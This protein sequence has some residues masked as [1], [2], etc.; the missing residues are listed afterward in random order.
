M[1]GFTNKT[2]NIFG[3]PFTLQETSHPEISQPIYI[4]F[5]NVHSLTQTFGSTAARV[6]VKLLNDR[7]APNVVTSVAPLTIMVLL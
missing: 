3:P 6:P 4:L 7:L 1:Y 2:D 5:G